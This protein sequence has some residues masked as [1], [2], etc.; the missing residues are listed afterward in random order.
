MQIM[1]EIFFSET[2]QCLYINYL[3]P[4]LMSRTSIDRVQ[5]VLQDCI[6]HLCSVSN[7]SVIHNALTEHPK[8]LHENVSI[9]TYHPTIVDVPK[10]LFISTQIAKVY[11]TMMESMMVLTYQTVFPGELGNKWHN[12]QT[13]DDDKHQLSGMRWLF[14]T[15]N[16]MIVLYVIKF[17][18]SAPVPLQ[19]L[20][21]RFTEPL[22]LG[23]LAILWSYIVRSWVGIML[24]TFILVLLLG[25]LGSHYLRDVQNQQKELTIQPVDNTQE[26]CNIRNVSMSNTQLDM[27]VLQQQPKQE[28]SNNYNQERSF[29]GEN[30]GSLSSFYSS[31]LDRSMRN[32]NNNSNRDSII[33]SASGSSEQLALLFS[34][35]DEDYDDQPI[36]EEDENDEEEW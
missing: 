15:I 36:Y 35:C 24:F 3:L 8:C 28:L 11:P 32:G 2:I 5:Q 30:N 22:F 26:I 21:I 1:L 25:L 23:G 10:Y 12:H 9:K 4:R 13:V 34:S 19:K 20:S 16:T 14:A 17:M 31:S 18:T 33:S 29:D 7:H 27:I 6:D